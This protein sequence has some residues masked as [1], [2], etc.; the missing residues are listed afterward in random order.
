MLFGQAGMLLALDAALSS[1]D[2]SRVTPLRAVVYSRISSD[3]LELALG[4]ERQE[5]DC[6]RLINERGWV[7][8]AGPYRENDTSASTRSTAKRPVYEAM[9]ADLRAGTAEVLV[10][11]STSRLT[12]RP[13]DYERLIALVRE[14]GLQI[15]TVVSGDVDL[16]TADGRAIARVLSAMD[17]VEAERTGERIARAALQRAEK[18]E[19]HGGAKPPWGYAFAAGPGKLRLVIVEERAA[20]V[21]EAATRVLAGQSLYAIRKDWNGRGALT[22]A[23]QPWRSAGVRKMLVRGS[24]AGYIERRG[25]LLKGS[26]EP[27][28]DWET[29]QQVRA[30]LTDPPS[31]PGTTWPSWRNTRARGPRGTHY[32]LTGLVYCGRCDHLM[33]SSIVKYGLT[34]WCPDMGGC[35]HMRIRGADLEQLLHELIAARHRGHPALVETDPVLTAL[36]MQGNQLQDDH[37]DRLLDRQDFLR[38]TDRLR[39]KMADR[40]REITGAYPGRVFT[41]V[42]RTARLDDPE[43]ILRQILHEH[44]Q[45]VVV[46]PHAGPTKPPREWAARAS[47]MRRRLDVHWQGGEVSLRE[48]LQAVPQREGLTVATWA[49]PA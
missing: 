22:T 20:M 30:V 16:A 8:G 45:R 2:A 23:G 49:P 25:R 17:A 5:Q 28:L 18:G 11:Y 12:R 9:L 15:F 34:Y 47:Q 37:Y 1:A 39:Q 10:A 35:G 44:L 48:E 7:Q 4:V 6:L 33:Y 31:L 13:L 36:R 19:W 14:T 32:P 41:S 26:W 24:A 46:H 43:P 38:Q 42:A 27:I 21:R 40:R 3:P 29:W